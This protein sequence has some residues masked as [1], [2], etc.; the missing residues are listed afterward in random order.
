MGWANCVLLHKHRKLFI[1]SSFVAENLKKLSA[2]H[3]VR[4]GSR[5]SEEVSTT[6]DDLFYNILTIMLAEDGI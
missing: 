5:S 4:G 1:L 2:R 6:T 3:A